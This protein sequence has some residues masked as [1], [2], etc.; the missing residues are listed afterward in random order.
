MSWE[1]FPVSISIGSLSKLWARRRSLVGYWTGD[2]KLNGDKELNYS[3]ELVL[4]TASNRSLEGLLYYEGV[5]G[6][7]AV[8]CRG[9]DQLMDGADDE[10]NLRDGI[11]RP[12]FIRKA[13]QRLTRP[14]V[15]YNFH[16]PK[17]EWDCRVKHSQKTTV[18]DFEVKNLDDPRALTFRGK[19]YRR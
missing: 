10:L 12:R 16:P 3:L 9:V 8:V 5:V 14:S 11:W 1:F 17:Y 6:T 15:A 4:T 7:D 19:C 18:M 13:H 2:F